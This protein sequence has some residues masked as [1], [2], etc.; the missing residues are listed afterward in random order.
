MNTIS[1]DTVASTRFPHSSADNFEIKV[2]AS[3]ANLGP[4]F[5]TLAVAVQLYLRLRVKRLP[6]RGELYFHFVDHNLHGENCIERAY[7]SLA[8]ADFD[9]L[10]SL[11]VE[12]RSE[13]PMQ[14]GLGSS[15]AATVAGLRLYEAV[16]GPMPVAMLLNA[17]YT[18]ESHPDNAAA[19]LLGGLTISCQ[20]SHDAVHAT[21]VAWPDSLDFV[22]LTP[23]QPLATGESRAVLPQCISR[24]DAVFNLQRLALL[25]NSLHSGDYSQLRHALSDRLHQPARQKIVPALAEA[26]ALQ[27]PGLLG[28]CLSGAGPS[29]VAIAE[30][31][32]REIGRLLG[33]VYERCGVS[34]TVR[35]LQAHHGIE[36]RMPIFRSGLLCC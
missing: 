18:L 35:T 2:P 4:G 23:E 31:N 10:P 6:G 20:L 26:L 3:I 19:S 13:I 7:R 21:S 36:E 8:G 29:I 11:S 28:V 9:R 22:V 15:A 32:H 14:A 34:H 12:V 5:D 30:R 1:M 33:S 24:A 17:A 25:L 27:H 16:A